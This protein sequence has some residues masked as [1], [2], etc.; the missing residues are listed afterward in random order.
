MGR[1]IDWKEIPDT[2]D[3]QAEDI[4]ESCNQANACGIEVL[5][6]FLDA[7]YFPGI[8]RD[9]AK[10]CLAIIRPNLES[11]L[12]LNGEAGLMLRDPKQFFG[13]D[14]ESSAR[15]QAAN[16][17]IAQINLQSKSAVKEAMIMHIEYGLGKYYTVLQHFDFAMYPSDEADLGESLLKDT[18]F[19]ETS[20]ISPIQ[21]SQ[22]YLKIWQAEAS[23]QA[24][25]KQLKSSQLLLAERLL[26]L[27]E[28]YKI[29][30]F[31]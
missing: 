6:H 22:P 2:G 3:L 15:E 26:V 8:L 31:N 17:Y 12:D 21:S 28:I 9:L 11:E 7:K 23:K 4:I 29:K 1:S 13:T 27:L 30:Q 14:D 10:D 24:A 16:R 20:A 5:A 18:Q 19:E 25:A